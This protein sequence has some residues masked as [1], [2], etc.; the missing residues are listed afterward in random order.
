MPHGFV[1]FFENSSFCI[2]KEL[3]ALSGQRVLDELL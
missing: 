2:K 1:H 3:E